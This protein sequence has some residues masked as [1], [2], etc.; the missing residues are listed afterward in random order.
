MTATVRLR[1]VAAAAG[2]SAGTV[3]N[4]FNRPEAVRPE[5][6]ERVLAAASRLGYA[7]PAPAARALRRGR[8][9][10]I[11]LVT[12]EAASYVLSDPFG[13]RLLS[14]IAAVCDETGDGLT[15]ASTAAAAAGGWSIET[16][17][18]DGFILFCFAE[19][20]ETL[21]QAR[22]RGLPLV[23]V[24]SARAPGA[25][26]VGIDD[27]GAAAEAAR[28]VL[29]LGHRR[30]AILSTELVKDGRVGPVSPGRAARATAAGG[31]ARLAGYRAALT[32]AGLDPE[33]VP[34]FET[35]N[36]R[37]SVEAAI[38]FLFDR[39]EPP[40]AL[41]A[42]SD[43]IALG[44]LDA[45]AARG[46]RAPSDVSIVGFDDG[47]EAVR[48]H[49][50]LTTV[51]QPAEEKG[52]AAAEMLLGLRPPGD[53]VLPAALVRRATCGPPPPER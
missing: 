50:P 3:S 20:D 16:A 44:A 29:W 17:L 53:L 19:E 21:E 49:P 28:H 15:I 2:V 13:R 12:D 33:A 32:E 40:T 39:P 9:H 22:R 48:A 10:L 5:L 26:S 36:D 7:G 38:R 11:A 6:R 37:G 52:R 45:L 47:P 43:V 8:A 51:G 14:G 30:I 27:A 24:D 41:L 23:T 46:L 1:D 18:V 34:V 42:M 35:E 31:R 4:V 25:P